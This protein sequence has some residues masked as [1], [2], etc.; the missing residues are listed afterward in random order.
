VRSA[1]G[2]LLVQVSVPVSGVPQL[3][4]GLPGA[5]RRYVGSVLVGGAGA[6][7][8]AGSETGLDLALPPLAVPG[9]PAAYLAPP[10][11]AARPVTAALPAARELGQGAPVVAPPAVRLPGV[12]LY[13]LASVR[14]VMLALAV[15][16]LLLLA[17]WRL[18]VHRRW[19]S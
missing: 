11:T 2:G 14:A 1:A 16:P 7:V 9:S 13:P 6:V 17:S 10:V 3:V 15:V 18:W 5:N 4:P 19:G 8:A 12:L